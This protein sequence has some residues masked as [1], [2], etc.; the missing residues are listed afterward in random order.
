[1]KIESTKRLSSLS[2]D[3]LVCLIMSLEHRANYFEKDREQAIKERD[4][5]KDELSKV[6]EDE[7]S[8]KDDRDDAEKQSKNM[9]LK[10]IKTQAERDEALADLEAAIKEWDEALSR[11]KTLQREICKTGSRLE[12]CTKEE[13]AKSRGWPDIFEG[14][15]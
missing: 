10:V 5:L 3:D 11:E 13:Y 2:K 4:Y 9:A 12:P 14:G 7:Q 1:M 6:L 8:T 15:E